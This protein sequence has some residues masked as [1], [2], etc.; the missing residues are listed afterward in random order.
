VTVPAKHLATH[1]DLQRL[2]ENVRGEII[3]GELVVQPSPTPLQ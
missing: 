3:A 2:P 1:A